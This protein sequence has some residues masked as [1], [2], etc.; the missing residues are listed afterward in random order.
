MEPG[1]LIA[2]AIIVVGSC[3]TRQ[4]AS[5]QSPVFER[6]IV[7]VGATGDVISAVAT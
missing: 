2:I 3:R 7:T 4:A 6:R 5:D 1:L